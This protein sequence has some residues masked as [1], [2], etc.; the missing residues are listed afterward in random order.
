MFDEEDEHINQNAFTPCTRL[1]RMTIE[2]QSNSQ[3]R[4][5]TAHFSLP[6]TNF[7]EKLMSAV[8]EETEEES[9]PHPNLDMF[10][11][12]DKISMSKDNQ[13]FSFSEDEDSDEGDLFSSSLCPMSSSPGR[14]YTKN[15]IF[16][17]EP[18]PSFFDNEDT[19]EEEYEEEEEEE[20]N[21]LDLTDCWLSKVYCSNNNNDFLNNQFT[22]NHDQALDE[23]ED[24]EEDEE[25]RPPRFWSDNKLEKKMKRTL[26]LEEDNSAHERLPLREIRFEDYLS[27]DE[28]HTKKKSLLGS[29]KSHKMRYMRTL[30]PPRYAK[31]KGK[32]P[33][34]NIMPLSAVL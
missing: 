14:V 33:A 27:D 10:L 13:M 2:S 34:E 19:E 22:T 12:A 20:G 23:V 8:R 16:D 26:P 18:M 1:S 30:S 15:S 9:S 4:T 11:S 31:R 25:N 17:D 6:V 28:I 29:G 24:S 3:G 21:Y 7:N 5:R 32:E